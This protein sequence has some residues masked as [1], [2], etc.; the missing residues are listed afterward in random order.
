MTGLATNDHIL[1]PHLRLRLHHSPDHLALLI[2]FVF[3]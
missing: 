2:F 3:L 1:H